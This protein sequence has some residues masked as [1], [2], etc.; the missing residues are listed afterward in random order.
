MDPEQSG[1]YHINSRKSILVIGG[2]IAGMEAALNLAEYGAKVYLVESSPTIG[3]LMARLNKTFPT[4]DCSICIEA[5]KMYDVQ[6][7]QN[8]ELLTYTDVRR[9]KYVD[10]KYKVRLVKKSRFVD[11]DKCKGCG[12]C[13]EVCPIT[14]N[15]ELDGKLGG[16]RKLISIPY[17]QAVPNAYVIDPNCRHGKMYNPEGGGACIGGC[18]VDC[19]QCRECQIAKCV[20]ACREEGAEAV[21][22]WG[23][24]ELL[25]IEVDSIIIATGVATL[26]LPE[27]YY[28]H[29]IYD[30]VITHL[31]YERLTNAGG[32]TLGEILRPSDKKHP[33]N[34]MWVQ[35]V[36]RDTKVGVTYCSK[37]CC[38]SSTKQAIITREHAE[39]AELTV[40]YKDL[41]TY[42]KDFFEFSNRAKQGGIKY[43]KGKLAEVYENPGSKNLIVTYENLETG[44]IT[45]QEVELLVLCVPLI[46]GE[47]IKRIAK[48]L[49]LPVDEETGFFKGNEDINSHLEST[50]PGVYLCG[51]ASGPVDISEAVTS[52]IAAS[53]KAIS[54]NDNN[55]AGELKDDSS[56]STSISNNTVTDS[57][58]SS[59][60]INT[61]SKTKTREPHEVV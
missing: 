50:V 3:G 47:N 45:S 42:G 33:K 49:K 59:T 36:G 52:A 35:C 44:E 8:I 40:L 6:R 46:P 56:S 10:G 11:E 28:G 18:D 31:E 23:K 27:G 19:I 1:N 4:N 22:L 34:I 54:K 57:D 58:S 5:P 26:K 21:L 51:G 20:V 16:T 38:M 53:M 39:D 32:P 30:N 61:S 9:A 55:S 37:I 41:K 43:T 2:G 24:D 12:K 13:V 14:V 60:S 25:D 17:P 15:D 29:D 7:N 48:A